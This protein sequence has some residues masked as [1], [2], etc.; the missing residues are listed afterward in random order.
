MKS[1]DV[2]CKATN[3]IHNKNCECMAGVITVK[4]VHS[5]STSETT[6]DTFVLE[7]G[8]TFDNLAAYNDDTKTVVEGINCSA[9]NSD[10]IKKKNVLQ[11]KF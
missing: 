10:L 9:I 4:G 6:C 8:Y 3:C 5:H 7:G 2:T 11:I 1:A